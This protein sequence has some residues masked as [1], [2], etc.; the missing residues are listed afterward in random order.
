M[1]YSA[2]IYYITYITDYCFSKGFGMLV[3]NFRF[4]LQ[5]QDNP[6]FIVIVTFY[7]V[8]VLCVCVGGRGALPQLNWICSALCS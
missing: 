4:E 5:L 1:V 3:P 7:C 6:P 8:V 2:Q